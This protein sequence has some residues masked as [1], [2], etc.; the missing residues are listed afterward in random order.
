[1]CWGLDGSQ[2]RI[3]ESRVHY[4]EALSHFGKLLQGDTKSAGDVASVGAGLEEPEKK[5]PSR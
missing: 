1:M 2:N 5:A 4:K 3:E